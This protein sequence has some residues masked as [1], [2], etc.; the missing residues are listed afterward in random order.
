M[1]V[2]CSGLSGT[3]FGVRWYWVR[4]LSCGEEVESTGCASPQM[5][6]LQ[7]FP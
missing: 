7:P 3:H 2:C 1:V 6:G 4:C 5:F